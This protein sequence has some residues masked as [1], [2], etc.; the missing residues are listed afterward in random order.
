MGA[1]ELGKTPRVARL[2]PEGNTGVFRIASAIRAKAVLFRASDR[3]DW[4]KGQNLVVAGGLSSVSVSP[5][6][7][8]IL[9][10]SKS[11]SGV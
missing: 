10:R 8:V 7:E 4:I 9:G 6:K 5:T 3:A 11:V 1:S 2:L